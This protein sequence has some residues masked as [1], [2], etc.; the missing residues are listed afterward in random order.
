MKQ[1]VP[2]P[3]DSTV[4]KLGQGARR[5]PYITTADAEKYLEYVS[6]DCSIESC[7]RSSSGDSYEP[8]IEA[9]MGWL[10]PFKSNLNSRAKKKDLTSAPSNSC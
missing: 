4:K 8:R 1:L 7:V 5:D 2:K 10:K 6:K 3:N 9:K